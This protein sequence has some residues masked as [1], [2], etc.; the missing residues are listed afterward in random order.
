MFQVGC[1]SAVATPLQLVLIVLHASV[2]GRRS[3][4]DVLAA[5][6]WRSCNG[7]DM[8]VWPM[9]GSPRVGRLAPS[10]YARADACPQRRLCVRCVRWQ[11]VVETVWIYLVGVARWCGGRRA[12]A[13][14]GTTAYAEVPVGR[15]GK[16]SACSAWLFVQLPILSLQ[17]CCRCCANFSAVVC[18]ADAAGVC[19]TEAAGKV[20][21]RTSISMCTG[22]VVCRWC[23]VCCMHATVWLAFTS[24]HAVRDGHRVA[25]ARMQGTWRML[26]GPVQQNRAVMV[27]VAVTVTVCTLTVIVHDAHGWSYLTACDLFCLE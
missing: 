10:L 19:S 18:G 20:Q 2:K 13:T 11:G 16:G 7:A 1:T 9:K 23:R 14:V 26:L 15:V 6:S 5:R 4:C 3:R 24:P 21:G 12:V 17:F 8:W 27:T 25:S 22:V